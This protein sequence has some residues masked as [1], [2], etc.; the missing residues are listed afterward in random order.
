MTKEGLPGKSQVRHSLELTEKYQKP[1]QPP[2]VKEQQ[3]KEQINSTM[4]PSAAMGLDLIL[5]ILIY[6]FSTAWYWNARHM[7][8]ISLKL[9]VDINSMNT[10]DGREVCNMHMEI[11]M[12][13]IKL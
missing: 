9:R 2:S 3:D 13:E 6:W 4:T 5:L 1:Q 8:N 11:E 7:M 12:S 10:E